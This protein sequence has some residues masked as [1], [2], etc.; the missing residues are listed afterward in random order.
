MK[1][2]GENFD[3]HGGGID[4]VFPHHENEIA[5]SETATG[6]TFARF[7][8]HNGLTRVKTKLPGGE[9][10]DEKMAKSLGNIKPLEELLREF[11]PQSIRF[12]LLSTHY[13]RP[14]DFS[15]D[16]VKA[17]QKGIMNIYRLLERVTRLTDRDVYNTACSVSHLEELAQTEPDRQL[18]DTVIQAQLKYLEALDDDFNTAQALATL[19]DLCSHINRHIDQQKLEF[20]A[21]KDAQLLILEA[22]RMVTSLGQTLGLLD[23]PLETALGRDVLTDQLMDLLIELRADARKNKNFALSDAI[24]DKL[25]K[26]NIVIEDLPDKTTIWRKE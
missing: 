18:K 26:L 24:R 25:N 10:K 7:W 16:A 3:I 17:A 11:P 8:M 4:L 5:Q 15:D 6:K 13:R 20:R 23:G 9:L 1:Y 14:L 12:F 2:L 22:A 19:F 21:P